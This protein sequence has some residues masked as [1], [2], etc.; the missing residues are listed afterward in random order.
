M[1]KKFEHLLTPIR[2]GSHLIKNRLVAAPAKPFMLQGTERYPSEPIIDHYASKARNGAGL[3]ICTGTGL[4]RE[5]RPV[6]DPDTVLAKRA[7]NPNP[8]NPDR[9]MVAETGRH[10]DDIWDLLNGY[11]QHYIAHLS[12]VIH[13]YGAKC[14]CLINTDPFP[15]YDVSGGK[16]YQAVVGNSKAGHELPPK[17]ELTQEMIR[18]IADDSVLQAMLLKECG[19]DGCYLNM[20]YRLG[21]LG[22]LLSPITNHRTDRYGGSMENR[23]SFVI[24][25]CDRIKAACGKDF[26]IIATLSGA[27]PEGGYTNEDAVEFARLFTGHIDMLQIEGSE[28][29]SSHVDYFCERTPHLAWAEAIKKGA[30]G[31]LVVANGGLQDINDSE[32]AIAEG[33]ADFVSHARA[34]I[35]NPDYGKLVQEGRDKDVVPCLRCNGCHLMSYYKP[36]TNFC[37]VNPTYGLAHKL[38]KLVQP[39]ERKKKVAVV[40]GGPAGME[41]AILSAQRGHDVTLFEKS[42]ALG[43][44]L[45]IADRSPIKWA[46]RDFKNYMVRQVEKE[47]IDLRLNTEATPESLEGEH[48]DAVFVAVGAQP[49]RLPIP[50]ADGEN[51]MFALDAFTREPELKKTVV[52]IGGGQVGVE[53][54]M[55]LAEKGH[56]VTVLEAAGLLARDSSMPL[57]ES[58]NRAWEKLENFHY[59]VNATCTEIRDGA[60]VYTDPEGGEHTVKAESVVLATGSRPEPGLERKFLDTAAEVIVIG[61]ADFPNDVQRAMR[62]AFGAAS[63]V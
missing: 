35:C 52:V 39:P 23:A 27:E 15:D 13:L 55:E 38:D 53:C 14:V 32:A 42:D 43:G 37:A 9:G 34:W 8:W 2:V 40:G 4:L 20:G 28:P 33:K 36:W 49:F 44:L 31:I 46:L 16:F 61:D 1:S 3:I 10:G 22:R 51:V 24:D 21:F 7:L 60:V 12:E 56:D 47:R 58:I 29:G 62:S 5:V 63:I 57:Y 30:P 45:K 41:A 26:L 50:G 18:Q 17:K 6:V 11:C 54:A 48:F 19:F 59:A 25:V